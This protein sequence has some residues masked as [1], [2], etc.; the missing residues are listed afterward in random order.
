MFVRKT[1][2]ANV[3]KKERHKERL[4]NE[5]HFE[6]RLQ[7]IKKELEENH[8]VFIHTMLQEHRQVLQQKDKEIKLLKKEMEAHEWRYRQIRKR[9]QEIE[10]LSYEVEGVI[11]TMVLKVQESLQPFYRT[12]AKVEFTKRK[13][14]KD[15]EKVESIFRAIK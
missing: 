11:D 3:I 4:Q 10:E 2:I 1:Q 9:E 7:R 15:H 12:R 8:K 5:K 13:S 14:D 6:L